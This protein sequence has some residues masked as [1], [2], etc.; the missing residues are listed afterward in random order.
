MF[1]L[2]RDIFAKGV[3]AAA[4]AWTPAFAQEEPV[5]QPPNIIIIVADDL[6]YTDIGPFGGEISTPNLD[7]LAASGARLAAFYAAPVCSPSRAMLLT[8]RDSHEVGLGANAELR[9]P[10]QIGRDGYEGFLDDRA[11]TLAERL[12]DGGYSTFMAGK[13][14]L[15]VEP[16]QNPANRG[17]ERSFALLQGAHNHFGYDQVGDYLKIDEVAGYSE[18]GEVSSFPIGEYSSDYFTDRFLGFLQASPSDH[19]FFG[20]L[21]FTAP[22]WPLQAP[23]ELIEKYHGKYDEGPEELRNSRLSSLQAVGLGDLTKTALAT[24]D[25][26]DEMSLEQREIEARKMEIYAAMVDRMDYDIG[27]V[28]TF[29]KERGQLDNTI[30]LFMSDNGPDGGIYDA[31]LTMKPQQPGH[32]PMEILPVRFDNSRGA[33]GSGSSF[34]SYGPRWAAAG[35]GP[36]SGRK[37]TVREGGIR[38]PAIVTGPGIVNETIWQ[39]ID[40]LDVVPTVLELAHVPSKCVVAGKLSLE[41]SGTSRTTLLQGDRVSPYFKPAIARELY[42]GRTIR[43]GNFKAVYQPERDDPASARWMLFDVKNDPS[44]SND[45]AEDHPELLAKLVAQ[46]NDYADRVGVLR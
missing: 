37:G 42:F 25:D 31:P 45:I 44:E 23:A 18:D 15:G 27:R 3:I 30:I 7:R 26:W 11:A 40:I 43:E 20:Y 9:L 8:G 17:F 29:L 4:L 35:A 34:I 22:H 13:W 6:G 28:I 46:W 24:Q 41:P 19:P 1:R 5:R 10:Q 36:F 33:L 21:A 2:T 32:E 16:A 14:H 38:V 39:P 12:K